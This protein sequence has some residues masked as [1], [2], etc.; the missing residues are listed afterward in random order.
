MCD[1]RNLQLGP[2]EQML[3]GTNMD[4]AGAPGF[5]MFVSG[6]VVGLRLLG[7]AGW[8]TRVVPVWAS[9]LISAAGSLAFF[10]PNKV[11]S[12]IS[13]IVLTAGLGTLGWTILN[14]SDESWDAP[15]AQPAAARGAGTPGEA[16]P[17]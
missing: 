7:I 2:Q 6:G 9:V 12:I 15:R 3:R 10:G 17:A 13:F 1:L 14:S 5:L 11:V 16:T 4:A 8:S